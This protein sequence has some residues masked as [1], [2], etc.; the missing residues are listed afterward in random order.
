MKAYRLVDSLDWLPHP[1]A[2]GVR[3]KP[4]ITSKEHA[5]DVTC[6]IVEVPEGIEVPEHIHPNQEDILYPL[7]GRAVMWV[8]GEEDFVLEPGVIVKVPKGVKHKI[9][10]VTEDLLIYDVFCPALF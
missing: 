5:L 9:F 2:A 10:D 8:E 4:M 3:I 6:M 1:T 7:K